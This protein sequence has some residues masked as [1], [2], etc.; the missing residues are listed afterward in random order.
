M[1][2]IQICRVEG[3]QVPLQYIPLRFHLR[4]RALAVK[5]ARKRFIALV[6]RLPAAKIAPLPPH[7]SPATIEAWGAA[8]PKPPASQPTSRYWASPVSWYD[9]RCSPTA[10]GV[11]AQ[12]IE[13]WLLGRNVDRA[14]FFLICKARRKKESCDFAYVLISRLCSQPHISEFISTHTPRPARSGST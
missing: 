10:R 8:A 4:P 14:P 1:G 11:P 13:K 3:G 12:I 6:D 9:N 7:M 2:E 5:S